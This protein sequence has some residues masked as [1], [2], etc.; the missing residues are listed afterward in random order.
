MIL[1][2]S[3]GFLQPEEAAKL[4]DINSRIS[5]HLLPQ[6]DSNGFRRLIVALSASGAPHAPLEMTHVLSLSPPLIT[7][8]PS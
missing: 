7:P 4:K 2:K 3:L 5:T 8:R 6:R 1:Q